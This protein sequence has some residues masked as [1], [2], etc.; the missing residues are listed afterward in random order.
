MRLH[1][2]PAQSARSKLT[3][4][5]HHLRAEVLR[6]FWRHF[7]M[8]GVTRMTKP[9]DKQIPIF[10]SLE[11]GD[12]MFQSEQRTK[13]EM[14]GLFSHLWLVHKPNSACNQLQVCFCQASFVGDTVNVGVLESRFRV[15]EHF[16]RCKSCYTLTKQS[17]Y[18]PQ[19]RPCKPKQTEPLL[20]CDSKDP[21]LGP[22]S[23]FED[24]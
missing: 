4:A 6:V 12:W 10:R 18:V 3:F 24:H 13:C 2:Q 8:H 11:G 15:L 22:V 19:R 5:S 20:P 7:C 17:E 9:G 16:H 21:A 14:A 1:W 23:T